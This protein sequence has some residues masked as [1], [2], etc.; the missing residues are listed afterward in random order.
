MKILQQLELLILP[1]LG[2]IVDVYSFLRPH[3]PFIRIP[4]YGLCDVFRAV[5]YQLDLVFYGA[6]ARPLFLFRSCFHKPILCD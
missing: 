1:T 4:K 5:W 6:Y 3:Y 2:H